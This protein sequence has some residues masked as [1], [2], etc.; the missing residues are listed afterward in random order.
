MVFLKIQK[1][2]E[3]VS[4]FYVLNGFKREKKKN[5]YFIDLNKLNKVKNNIIQI[6]NKI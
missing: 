6:K 2:N 4:N 3:S 1:K 5:V